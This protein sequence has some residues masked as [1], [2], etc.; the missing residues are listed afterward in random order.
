MSNI[1]SIPVTDQTIRSYCGYQCEYKV[2]AVTISSLHLKQLSPSDVEVVARIEAVSSRNHSYYDT[3]VHLPPDGSAILS[4]ACSCPVGPRCKHVYRVLTRI[5]EYV[6]ILLPT[7]VEEYASLLSV[8]ARSVLSLDPNG[9][10]LLD[11]ARIVDAA[12]DVGRFW[13]ERMMLVMAVEE[14]HPGLG[15]EEFND[16]VKQWDEV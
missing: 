9:N 5:R 11:R 12:E 10:T 13:E 15:D 2:S 3:T 1:R 6:P 8:D 4:A 14:R 16:K 7:T